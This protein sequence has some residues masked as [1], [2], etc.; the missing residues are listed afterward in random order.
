MLCT[1]ANISG[2]CRSRSMSCVSRAVNFGLLLGCFIPTLMGQAAKFVHFI[3]QLSHPPS[4]GINH[5]RFERFTNGRLLNHS[6]SCQTSRVLQQS[7]RVSLWTKIILY[8][9]SIVREYPTRPGSF[10][11]SGW[12]HLAL[13]SA[14]LK[15]RFHTAISSSFPSVNSELPSRL[16]KMSGELMLGIGSLAPSRAQPICRRNSSGIRPDAHASKS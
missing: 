15:P 5:T 10:P 2:C 13:T 1:R 9:L 6:R 14:S 7:W 8:G 11:A 4:P 16:P 12:F 3:L